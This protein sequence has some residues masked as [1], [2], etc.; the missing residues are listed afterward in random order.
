MRRALSRFW[1]GLR[2]RNKLLLGYSVL[3]LGITLLSSSVVY[4][5]VRDSVRRSI[6][7][8]L[9]T[10]VE[11]ILMMVRTSADLSV[12]NRLRAIAEKNRDIVQAFAEKITAS[13]LGEEEAK[14]RA[15]EVLLSQTIGETG[16]V[17]V[18]DST[19]RVLVHPEQSLV[20]ESV[21]EYGFVQEQ[22]RR[23]LGYLEYDWKNPGEDSERPK[24][25]YM[26]Y[27]EPWDWIISA[28]SYRREFESLVSVSDLR[29]LILSLRFGDTGYS[30]VL[31]SS[32]NVILHPAARGNMITLQDSTGLEFIREIC[33]RRNGSIVYTWRNPG[34]TEYR[35]KLAF[36][37]YVPEY[38]WIV[39]SASYHDEF[40]APL[41][42]LRTTHVVTMIIVLALIAVVSVVLSSSITGP[43]LELTDTMRQAAQGDFSAR[44]ASR[45]SDE[46][47]QLADY[48]NFFMV[49]LEDELRSR[50]HAEAER[51]RIEDRLRKSEKLEAIGQLAGGVAHDFNNLLVPIICNGEVLEAELVDERSRGIVREMIQAAR[52]GSML[53][54]RMLDFGQ[55]SS[56]EHVTVNV[57]EQIDKVVELLKHSVGRK[58]EIQRQLECREPYIRGDASRL[59]NALLNLGL[60]ARDAMPDGG[61]LRFET[62]SVETDASNENAGSRRFV[63]VRVVDTGIGMTEEQLQH[64]FEPFFTTKEPGKGTGLG[65]A[66]V[67][68]T[69][70]AHNGTVDVVS[71]HGGGAVFSLYFPQIQPEAVAKGS[72][73]EPDAP[74]AGG[75]ILVADDETLVLASLRR[76]LTSM[77]YEVT[78]CVNGL[79]AVETMR[80]TPD[81]F[82]LVLL[83][84][85][86]PEM[87]GN[88]ALQ[89]IRNI[90]P[91]IPVV[92]MSGHTVRAGTEIGIPDG[93][94]SYIVKPFA[95]QDLA[96]VLASHLQRK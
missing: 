57:H 64:V 61:V 79:E 89:H 78:T 30:Y 44:V 5:L 25:L 6:E 70:T 63:R 52:R 11:S 75:H 40:F 92:I 49:R 24:A 87:Y 15:A 17:Y 84:L 95:K 37:N 69:L 45:S 43:V 66:S 76:V 7:Q 1:R 85:M 62:A 80:S 67:Y 8:E 20:G 71:R 74:E 41:E 28:S 42:Q 72:P 73:D 22:I 58:I 33:D 86:M 59:Q 14:R 9:E 83:D 81:A 60:N 36:F 27:F 96:S 53:T 34:E 50:R 38:D 48:F 16:Y 2:I 90:R 82:D 35:K 65:L 55:Q 3:F 31:D 19:A 91:D 54:R 13:G 23:K 12:K 21:P 32:G 94:S 39:V 26:T 68:G 93:A 77:G 18:I 46:I 88:E 56:I 47:A 10:S 29:D 4:Y 51:R